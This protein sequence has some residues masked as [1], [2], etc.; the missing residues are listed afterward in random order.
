[1]TVTT[2]R[3][4]RADLGAEARFFASQVTPRVIAPLLLIALVVRASLGNWSAWDAVA[5]A[6]LIAVQP[7]TEWMIHVYILH[8]KPRTIFGKTIDPLI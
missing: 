3:M 1:M 8:W 4:P 6:G 2:D 7:F 5:V